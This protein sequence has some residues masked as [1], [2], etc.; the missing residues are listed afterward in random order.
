MYN[1]VGKKIKDVARGLFVVETIAAVVLGLVMMDA[2]NIVAGIFLL[3]IGPLVSWIFLLFTYGFGEMIEKISVMEK[4][5]EDMYLMVKDFCENTLLEGAG[6]IEEELE[7]EEFE[8]E[9][10][11]KEML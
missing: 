7:E 5:S 6:F 4:R 8:I 10:P 11:Q 1:D 2:E 9:E 3:V